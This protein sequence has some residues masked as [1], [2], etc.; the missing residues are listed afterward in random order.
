[1]NNGLAGAPAD[2][3]LRSALA[4]VMDPE[5]GMNIVMVLPAPGSTVPGHGPLMIRGFFGTVISLERA[6]ALGWRWGYLARFLSG[7]GALV[8]MAAGALILLA[9]GG[10]QPGT[11]AHAARTDR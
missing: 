1:M 8:L 7:L 3:A 5:V 6:V 9:A 2:A 4:S 11:A 10:L